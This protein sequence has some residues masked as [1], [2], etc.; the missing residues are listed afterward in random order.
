VLKAIRS[1]DKP[2]FELEDL[3]A[4]KNIFAEA[5]PENKHVKAK[6]RQQLQV[7]RDLGVIRFE[8]TGHYGVV[9]PNGH[10]AS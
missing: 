5:Y 6:I 10:G 8:G 7:L 2:H 1:L 4:R 9:V 3:Y